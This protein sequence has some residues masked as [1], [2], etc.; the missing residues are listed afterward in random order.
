MNNIII[1]KDPK[2]EK[3]I[4][5]AIKNGLGKELV[6][7]PGYY[8]EFDVWSCVRKLMPLLDGRKNKK[9]NTSLKKKGKDKKR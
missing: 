2:D 8:F 6:D 5:W 3:A 4:K 1:V 7:V 9:R